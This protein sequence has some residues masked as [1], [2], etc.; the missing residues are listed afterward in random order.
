[1]FGS[2]G[3]QLA[4]K[5][6]GLKGKIDQLEVVL[7]SGSRT[8]RVKAM[9]KRAEIKVVKKSVKAISERKAKPTK[10]A[11]NTAR[12]MVTTVNSWVTEFRSR[13]A[14]ESRSAIEKFFT[15]NP[16]PSET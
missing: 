11:R 1:M 12:E 15:G 16:Q 6:W 2:R 4:Y 7:E 3:T 14:E 13:R 5:Y 8:R 9:S 10:A